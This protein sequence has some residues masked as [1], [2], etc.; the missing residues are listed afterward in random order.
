MAMAAALRARRVLGAVV[1]AIETRE[2][3]GVVVHSRGGRR[4]ARASRSAAAADR[5]ARRSLATRAAA[6]A[7]AEG[8]GAH[9]LRPRYQR[10]PA[11]GNR[12]WESAARLLAVVD[13]AAAAGT[14]TG[15]RRAAA[16]RGRSSPAHPPPG[17]P[18][19]TM[20]PR[21]LRGARVLAGAR[22]QLRPRRADR[23][24]ELEPQP[25]LVARH[26]RLSRTRAE[27][28]LTATLPPPHGNV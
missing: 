28:R 1:T 25:P 12:H 8:R 26:L 27:S 3:D 6:A 22:A 5:A 18:P 20:R 23:R 17:A 21:Q 13:A 10:V 24:D 2:R 9:P 15:P 11:S 4:Y 7:G 14:T 16:T 19:S